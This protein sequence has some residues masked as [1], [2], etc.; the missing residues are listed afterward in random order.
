[1]SPAVRALWA[2]LPGP[3]PPAMT[4][5]VDCLARLLSPAQARPCP[6][7]AFTLARGFFCGNTR[8]SPASAGTILRWSHLTDGAPQFPLTR[9]AFAPLEAAFPDASVGLL[10]AV[11]SPPPVGTIRCRSRSFVW[12][13]SSFPLPGRAPLPRCDRPLPGGSRGAFFCGLHSL[14]A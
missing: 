1:M 2:A 5:Q 12:R 3:S 4:W 6:A 14:V 7:L 13:A 8:S 10:F 11:N 9:Y